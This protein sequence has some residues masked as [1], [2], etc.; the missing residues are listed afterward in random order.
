MKGVLF[1]MIKSLKYFFCVL[2]IFNYF[3]GC[4]N[5]KTQKIDFDKSEVRLQ[6]DTSINFAD[7]GY[8]RSLLTINDIFLS[9]LSSFDMQSRMSLVD[10][11]PTKDDF[12]KFISDQVLAWN[13][14]EIDKI[15]L[16]AIKISKQFKELNIKLTLPKEIIF[17]KTTGR[18]E[19]HAAYTRGNAI[20][21]PQKKLK[22]TPK[23]LEVLIVHELFHIHT[24]NNFKSREDLHNILGFKQCNDI[25]YD[26]PQHIAEYRIT[27]PDS[28]QNNFYKIVKKP[29]EGD[30]IKVVPI[31]VSHSDYKGGIFF[32]YISK[33]LIVV[34]GANPNIKIVY[35]EKAPILHSYEE[36]E[37]LYDEIGR[38][39]NYNY[40]PEEVLAS[41]FEFLY[42]ER[43]GLKDEVIVNEMKSLLNF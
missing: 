40:H 23:K 34:D 14:D 3:F 18:E 28:P 24:K 5:Q 16:C 22:R 31:L 43:K 13:S 11:E 38:D 17:I 12:V 42:I 6:T 21:L 15:S 9:S 10:K 36:V 35:D 37:G 27:N 29:G 7:V 39:T 32:K 30:N 2:I 19:G 25:T 33:K 26:L 41:Y 8:G 1:Q 4:S 20:I